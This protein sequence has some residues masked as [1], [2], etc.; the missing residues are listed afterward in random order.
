MLFMGVYNSIRSG[1]VV[2]VR[3]LFAVLNQPFQNMLSKKYA[4]IV[5]QN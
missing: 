3:S 4:F 5:M 1:Q 2:H